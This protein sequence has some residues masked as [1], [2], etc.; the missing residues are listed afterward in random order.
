MPKRLLFLAFLVISSPALFAQT[1]AFNGYCESGGRSAVV[2]GLSSTNKLQG[3]IP[4]CT[5]TVFLTGT[6]NPATIFK[7]ASGTPLGNP[8]TAN[9]SLPSTAAPGQWLF[10]AAINT[11]YDVVMSG[12]VPPLTYLLP[13][14]LTDL[15]V[16]GGGGG[17]GPTIQTNG[18]NNFSQT[19]LNHVNPAPFNGLNFAF[20][21]PSGG[22]ETFGVTGTLNN[23]GITHPQTTVNGQ[24][25]ALGGTCT[26]PPPTATTFQVEDTAVGV[27]QGVVDFNS[28]LPVAPAGFTNVIWQNDFATGRKSA[29]V[30]NANPN[31]TTFVTIPVGNYIAIY[32]HRFTITR[33]DFAPGSIVG[34]ANGQ[35]GSGTITM[36]SICSLS[37]TNIGTWDQY[38]LA[39][40]GLTA[41]DVIDVQAFAIQG[42]SAVDTNNFCFPTLAPPTYALA[43]MSSGTATLDPPHF[44]SSSMQQS[45]GATG[46]TGAQV[47]TATTVASMSV[48]GATRIN[49]TTNINSVGLIIH[50][51]GSAVPTPNKIYVRPPLGFDL[52]TNSIY[53]DPLFPQ[54][55]NS[56]LLGTEPNPGLSYGTAVLIT[57]TTDCVTASGV[58]DD[59]VLCKPHNVGGGS[60]VWAPLS[61][62]GGGGGDTIT[63]PG[64]TLVVGGTP[65]NTTLDVDT[66]HAFIWAAAHTF[67][68]GMTIASGHSLTNTGVADGCATWATG[69]L[70]S[71]ATPCGSGGGGSGTVS[72]QAANVIGK[73]TNAT[74]TGAQSALSDNGTTV[75]STEPVAVAVAGGQGGTFNATEGTAASAAS[76]HDILYADS[77]AHCLEYSANGG[78]FACLGTGGSS[79]PANTFPIDNYGCV[80]DGVLSTNTGTDNTSCFSTAL[81]AAVAAGGGTITFDCFKQYRFAA[82]IP[83]ITTNGIWLAGACPLKT[84]VNHAT[85]WPMVFSSSATAT[86]VDFHGSGLSTP[87]TGNGMTN[88]AVNRAVTATSGAIGINNVD[89]GGFIMNNVWSDDSIWPFRLEGTAAFGYGAFSNSVASWG[90]SGVGCPSG[91]VHGWDLG[92]DGLS[93]R[94]KYDTVA[95]SCSGLVLYAAYFQVPSADYT[96]DH[97]EVA[98]GGNNSI[99]IG[100][101]SGAMQDISIND[102][103][104]D[105]IG[106]CV[107]LSGGP[108]ASNLQITITGGANWCDALQNPAISLDH[109]I[110][111]S[112]VGMQMFQGSVLLTHMQYPVVK[113][114]QIKTP[115]VG[116]TYGFQLNDVAGGSLTGNTVTG[117]TGTQKGFDCTLCRSNAFQNNVVDGTSGVIG[118]AFDA[119]STNNEWAQSNIYGTTL[120]VPFTDAGT[121]NQL[122]VSSGFPITLGST[123]VASGSTTTTIAGLTLTSPTLGGTP[124][125][126][127]AT[128]FKL[129]VGATYTSAANG[130][131]GYAT[132]TP[133][134]HIWGNGADRILAWIPTSGITNGD[135]TQFS[136]SSGTLS[137]A[138]AGG[139]CGIAGGGGPPTGAAGG[140][141][142]GTYPNPTVAKINGIAVTGTPS[143]GFVPT[144][145]SS[146]AATWQAAGGGYPTP[147][148]HTATSGTTTEL[149]FTSCISSSFNDY[150]IRG[151][152]LVG[153]SSGDQFFIQMSTDGGATYVAGTSYSYTLGFATSSAG[154]SGQKTS[155]AGIFLRD[156]NNPV[157]SNGSLDF[158]VTLHAP[159]SAI[160]KTVEGT[161]GTNITAGGGVVPEFTS[162]VFNST[163]AVNAFR[164]KATDTTFGGKITCQPLPN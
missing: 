135:C 96:L 68:L 72:G 109:G 149:D 40:V 39:D 38:S 41:A 92:S 84:S 80:G 98:G 49:T 29:Y 147:E 11:G 145:T 132:T 28:T 85:N 105:N 97:F 6:T 139:A 143:V 151:S 53:L 113:N 164:I 125:A 35:N 78:S 59:E 152:N 76:G 63:S 154:S 162:G 82:G 133:N 19:L 150:E 124:D 118:L 79:T 69:V 33:R 21:N 64:A 83:A 136:L 60:F 103:K 16:G 65:T 81:A 131:L 18:G 148:S 3:V 27:N 8:F 26:I 88:L 1:A 157:V 108:T 47:A 13:V 75:T 160:F 116:S 100:S 142:S 110:N 36:G 140:D 77:T 45:T 54:V 46:F 51:S 112:L 55:F 48:S 144:A 56:Y 107:V 31:I 73:A 104:F 91:T 102:P 86:I 2:Q 37:Y 20:S 61:S 161:A 137:L 122:S 66:S 101:A 156:S 129:P 14:T 111:T 71:T 134:W 17:V 57:N 15:Q 114:V 99:G 89:T 120:S 159:G 10:Y 67:S 155:Q 70:G 9:N 42:V 87:I 4:S 117:L 58:A 44:Q 5:V 93:T 32:P 126:S 146:S 34:S 130:E 94:M 62:S 121:N 138:D 90:F 158:R 95:N 25:C 7:D 119:T 12:G 115:G 43:T 30:P 153:S 106:Q 52:T 123:S 74:T 163:T 50:Y 22:I 23:S 128:Q 24:V 141:L 127:G